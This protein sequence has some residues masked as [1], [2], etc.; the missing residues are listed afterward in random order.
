MAE[1]GNAEK[2]PDE[3]DL[4]FLGNTII[5]QLSSGIPPDFLIKRYVLSTLFYYNDSILLLKFQI[6]FIH[7]VF[8]NFSF[9]IFLSYQSRQALLETELGSTL[10]LSNSCGCPLL[11]V[12]TLGPLTLPVLLS[13][14]E[15][16][17]SSLCKF[18]FSH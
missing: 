2:F 5:S 7:K 1:G 12:P 3:W 11:M 17:L 10:E 8:V 13:E 15:N 14:E 16:L 9:R 6:S 18:N 4:Q